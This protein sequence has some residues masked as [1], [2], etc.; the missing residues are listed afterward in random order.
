MPEITDPQSPPEKA[1]KPRFYSGGIIDD[2]PETSAR[3]GYSDDIAGGLG[4]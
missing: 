2:Y 4:R 1:Q 3:L